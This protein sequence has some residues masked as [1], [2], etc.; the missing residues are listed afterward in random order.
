M[1][2]PPGDSVALPTLP[3]VPLVVDKDEREYV[4]GLE[5]GLLII[6]AFGVLRGPATLTR[7]AEF[8]GHSKASVRRS[9]LTLC[10]LGF[11]VQT[12]REFQLAPRALRLG[13]AFV[14]SD[15]LT[16]VVQPILEMVSERTRES[17][18]IA[19]LDAQDVVFVA[20]S[21]HR[22]SLS[23]GLGAGARLPVYCS[24]TGRVLLSGRQREEVEFL[25]NR[26]SRPALT[27]HTRT[28]LPDILEAIER[29]RSQGYA[30]CDEELELGLRSIAVPVRSASG[31]LLAAMSL[32]VATSR[33][34]LEEAVRE[35]V[36]ELE[37]GRRQ[38]SPLL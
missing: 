10:R 24:A 15:R 17:A 13:H 12:G 5:K 16:R 33:M 18:S 30:T 22:R 28:A 4:M 14:V 36:P 21:T 19:V 37:L 23:T 26:M 29:A 8:T 1:Q 25:L 6:E 35:L 27:P 34:T 2:T 31:E 38:L 32:S 3:A 11:A 9:L 7:L 20:R